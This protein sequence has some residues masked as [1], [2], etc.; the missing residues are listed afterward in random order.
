MFVFMY[1]QKFKPYA[2]T[3][4]LELKIDLRDYLPSNHLCYHIESIVSSLD[5]TAIEAVYSTKGQNG[6][7]PKMMLSILFYGYAVGIRSGRKL[8]TACKEDLAFIYL[9]KSYQPGKTSINE[10]R[11]AHHLHFEGLFKELLKK[12]MEAGLIDT[13]QD[14]IDGSKIAANSA[15]KRTKT[16]GKYEKWLNHLLEDIAQ[17]EQELSKL[18]DGS[19]SLQV[20]NSSTEQA[21]IL[22]KAHATQQY[23]VDKVQGAI[24]ALEDVDEKKS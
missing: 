23:L 13:E 1:M 6:F 14:I 15:M 21:E 19:T 18:S 24:E 17:I 2:I 4:S 8:E 7:H 16:R 22:S 11:R 9:S 20:D 5:T 3:E 10:F 12:C